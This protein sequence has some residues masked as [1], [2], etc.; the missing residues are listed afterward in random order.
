MALNHSLQ[1]SKVNHHKRT[2]WGAW[3]KHV[4]QSGSDEVHS[5]SERWVQGG[6]VIIS[7]I[8]C[9]NL[10]VCSADK[11]IDSLGQTGVFVD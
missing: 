10:L 7:E 2:V 4:K 5:W 6:S 9:K 1:S 11:Q 8:S 3:G